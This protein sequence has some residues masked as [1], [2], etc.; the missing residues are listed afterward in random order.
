MTAPLVPAAAPTLLHATSTQTAGAAAAP[1][2]HK[3]AAGR[4][5]RGAV[6]SA[7]RARPPPRH[8]RRPPRPPRRR[9]PFLWTGRRSVRARRLG[10]DD[11]RRAAAPRPLVPLGGGRGAG[12]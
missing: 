9:P 11:P 7:A 12:G 6:A 5:R 2:P 4:A 1:P 10:A 3:H 8:R